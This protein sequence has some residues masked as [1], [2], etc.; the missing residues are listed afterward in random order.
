MTA[1]LSR[2]ATAVSDR[3][4]AA[5]A[6]T[7][8]RLCEWVWSVQDWRVH[9]LAQPRDEPPGAD[10]VATRCGEWHL[11]ACAVTVARR[12]EVCPRCAAGGIARLEVLTDRPRP[13]RCTECAR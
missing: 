9:A 7:A 6:R 4:P 2:R 12:G 5:G 3:P 1:V 13:A 11:I 8:A 10:A